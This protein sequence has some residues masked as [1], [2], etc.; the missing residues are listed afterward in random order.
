M[1][2]G[3][4]E[5]LK[6]AKSAKLDRSQKEFLKALKKKFS[7]NPPKEQSPSQN[8]HPTILVGREK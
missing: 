8:Y 5:K 6:M 1:Q 2:I 4:R 7:E 3:K